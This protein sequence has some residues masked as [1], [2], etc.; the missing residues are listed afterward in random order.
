MLLI[1]ANQGRTRSCPTIGLKSGLRPRAGRIGQ[2]DYFRVARPPQRRV[3][4]FWR[5]YRTRAPTLLPRLLCSARV[6][7]TFNTI[8]AGSLGHTDFAGLTADGFYCGDD[9]LAKA[10]VKGSVAARFIPYRP[11]GL[12][13]RKVAQIS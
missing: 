9:P 13:L 6:V 11:A 8:G 4:S 5:L 1:V 7:R 3:A 2:V 12:S 10:I